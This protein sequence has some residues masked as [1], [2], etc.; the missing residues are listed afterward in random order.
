MDLLADLVA[1]RSAAHAVPGVAVGVFAD[2]VEHYAFH[3]V[4]SIDNPL[5]VDVNTL[6]QFGSTGKTIHGDGADAAGGARRGRP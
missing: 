5:P 3:G 4:T 6:F 2:G 1:D